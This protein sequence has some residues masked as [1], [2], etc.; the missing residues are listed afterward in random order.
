MTYIALPKSK[1]LGPDCKV[2]EFRNGKLVWLGVKLSP[3]VI[4]SQSGLD[5]QVSALAR[6]ICS[7]EG[8]SDGDYRARLAIAEVVLNEA[9][10]KHAGNIL[11]LLTQRTAKSFAFT[12]G[13]YGEQKGR[14]AAT[15]A[16]HTVRGV[17]VA[18]EVLSPS[19]KPF[20][21]GALQFIN[22]RVQAGG[23]QGSA[24]LDPPEEKIREWYGWS[25]KDGKWEKTSAGNKWVGPIEGINTR[26]LMLFGPNGKTLEET[27]AALPEILAGVKGDESTPIL[28]DGLNTLS[29]LAVGGGVAIGVS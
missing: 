6:C 29:T 17:H 26:E 25:K 20:T 24:L 10:R 15:R 3:A 1:L 2:E 4:A 7:E 9:R 11:N 13:H 16:D 18:K 22:L 5:V 14:W 27:L 19:Y 8:E 28:E 12:A 23:R 21:K